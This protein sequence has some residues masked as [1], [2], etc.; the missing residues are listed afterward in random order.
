[1]HARVIDR[2][3]P[4]DRLNW[5]ILMQILNGPVIDRGERRLISKLH[6]NRRFKT[7]TGPGGDKKC[8]DWKSI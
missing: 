8:E 5:T 2:Q 3:K 6:M 1:M 4:F 7:K